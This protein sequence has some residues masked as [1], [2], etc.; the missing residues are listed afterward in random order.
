MC[1]ETR[2]LQ[3]ICIMLSELNTSS[4][5]I[6]QNI[7]NDGTIYSELRS[8]TE[9]DRSS[10]ESSQNVPTPEE[11][12]RQNEYASIDHTTKPEKP[13]PP[14]KSGSQF[15]QRLTSK[16]SSSSKPSKPRIPSKRRSLLKTLLLSK[17]RN[18]NAEVVAGTS[19]RKSTINEF[20]KI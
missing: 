10:K 13:A 16:L 3:L 19:H 5:G 8:T 7:G 18:S 2:Y 6:F 1:N 4:S 20:L 11:F 12:S 14:P 17:Y 9:G 15:K